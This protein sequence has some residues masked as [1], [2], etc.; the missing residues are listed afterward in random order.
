M[1]KRGTRVIVKPNY[2]APQGGSGTVLEV[3]Y[4]QQYPVAVE[5]DENP[6]G[7]KIVNFSLDEV[8]IDKTHEFIAFFA[9]LMSDY[10]KGEERIT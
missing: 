9:S 2:A 1:F 3:N 6:N 4:R 8:E 10:P 7:T 5:L